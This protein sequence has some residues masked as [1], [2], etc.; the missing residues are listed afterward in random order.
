MS[1]PKIVFLTGKGGV[2]KTSISATIGLKLSKSGKKVLLVSTDPAHSLSDV[3][4][5][6]IEDITE[7]KENL[8]ALE[9]KPNMNETVFSLID[10]IGS[11]YENFLGV[12]VSEELREMLKS[13]NKTPGSQ[14]VSVFMYL[15][16]IINENQDYDYIVFDTA[17]TGHTL[18]LLNLPEILEKQ[19][20]FNI[21]LKKDSS[22]LIQS[23]KKIFPF[24]EEEK[25]ETLI[26][27]QEEDLKK[28]VKNLVDIKKLKN[29]LK[30]PSATSFI[31]V[32]NPD[33][34]SFEETKR[35]RQS[36]KELEIPIK[37]LIINKVLPEDIKDDYF[38]EWIKI[39][40]EW[41]K[42]YDEEFPNI[43]K[44]LVHLLPREVKGLS[45]LEQL[46][47]KIKIDI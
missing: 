5:T 34:L 23:M 13:L 24:F 6:N 22:K 40:K 38:R 9:I 15:L 3:F 31:I 33:G 35:I 18:M 21:K 19:L 44:I 4:N 17:P 29:M 1:N 46:S 14:E 27:A 36:L 37:Y 26:K 30:D 41:I 25:E 10:N 39:Q 43:P 2:G 47:E 32:T 42:K 45:T 7:I 11:Q 20:S 28:L 8:H 12:D 16:K